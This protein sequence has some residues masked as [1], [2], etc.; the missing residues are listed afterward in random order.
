VGTLSQY[1][2]ATE[3]KTVLKGWCSGQKSQA[4]QQ[5]LVEHF[6]DLPK[7]SHALERLDFLSSE[8]GTEFEVTRKGKTNQ[9][10]PKA[11]LVRVLER[12]ALYIF[13]QDA[14]SLPAKDDDQAEVVAALEA[15]QE[16][17][18]PR[19]IVSAAKAE[20][21][22]SQ[23]GKITKGAN[24]ETASMIKELEALLR[25]AAAV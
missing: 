18:G 1:Q 11:T 23:L 21:I 2:R 13:E 25:S 7:R 24:K 9:T 10:L 5:L 16:S 15:L 4:L 12:I 19:L 8:F 14:T 17:T 20:A 6:E 22:R 3:V